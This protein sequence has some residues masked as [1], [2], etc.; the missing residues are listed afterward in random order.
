MSLE[1]PLEQQHDSEE[2]IENLD[3]Q[4]LESRLAEAARTSGDFS[5]EAKKWSDAKRER[6]TRPLQAQEVPKEV[7]INGLKES[8]GDP[9][10]PGFEAFRLS[11]SEKHRSVERNQ[12]PNIERIKLLLEA[13]QLYIDAGLKEVASSELEGVQWQIQQEGLDEL[14]DE[15]D[16][17]SYQIQEM[18]KIEE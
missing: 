15:F 13:I 5:P 3:M 9:N 7:I 4:E 16:N 18:D 2:N 6:A 17:L 10:H 12:E 1:N 11:M 8:Q 14:W